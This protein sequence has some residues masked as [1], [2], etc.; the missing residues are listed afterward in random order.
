MEVNK[1]LSQKEA[2]A[3]L[4]V[5]ARQVRYWLVARKFPIPEVFVG[6][7]ARWTKNQLDVWC[8]FSDAKRIIE[9]DRQDSA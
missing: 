5:S 7:R 8:N 1:L 4:G 9:E 6:N 3:Y 2:A